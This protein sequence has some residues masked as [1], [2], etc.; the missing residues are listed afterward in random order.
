M[1]LY[2]LCHLLK[3]E[4]DQVVITVM[5]VF[6][7]EQSVRRVRPDPDQTQ[8]DYK[9]CGTNTQLAREMPFRWYRQPAISCREFIILSLL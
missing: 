2:L 4:A 7:E 6:R 5:E 3:S 8:I 1:E 9:C